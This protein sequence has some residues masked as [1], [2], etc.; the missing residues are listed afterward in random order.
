M[1]LECFAIYDSATQMFG[2]PFFMVATG[3]ALRSFT[4]E[5]NKGDKNDFAAHPDDYSLYHLGTFHDSDGTWDLHGSPVLLVRGK[6]V[7]NVKG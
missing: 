6:D 4:D 5:V 7:V 3:A 2:R 1:K